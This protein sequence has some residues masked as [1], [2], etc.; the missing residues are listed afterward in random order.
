M[1]KVIIGRPINGISLN[2][3]EY[4][5]DEEGEVRYFDGADEAKQFLLDSGFSEKDLE[6]I[7]LRESCG[8]CSRCGAPLFK[9]DITGYN[10]QCF[11]CDEDFYAFEQGRTPEGAMDAYQKYQLEWML[12][13]GYSLQDLIQ[14]LTEYQYEDPEDSDRISTPISAIF[15]EWEQDVG[16]NSEIW[17]CKAEWAEEDQDEE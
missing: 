10:Y 6:F 11:R 1:K 2:G 15:A 16:F 14:A 9:S 7:V 17:A 13:H 5:L 12:S 8:V 4:V 3:L